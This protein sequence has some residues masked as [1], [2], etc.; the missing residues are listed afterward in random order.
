MSAVKV[1]LVGCERFNFKNELY[2]KGKVYMV[3]ETKAAIMLRKEDAFGR[4]YFST[5]VAPSKSTRDQRIAA[6][7]TMAA[8]AAAKEAAKAEDEIIDRQI[9]SD[10]DLVVEVDSDATVEVDTD[11]DPELDNEDPENP[12]EIAEADRDDGTAELV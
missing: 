8:I 6:A 11:D 4:P 2:E 9:D 1:R 5:Y 7:A 12:E 10:P 3:N